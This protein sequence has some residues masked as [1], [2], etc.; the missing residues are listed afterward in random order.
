MTSTT[1]APSIGYDAWRNMGAIEP[2]SPEHYRILDFI[3]HINWGA[4]IEKCY[5]LSGGEPCTISDKYTL[6]RSNFVRQIKFRNGKRWVVRLRLP[7]P[8]VGNED[9]N[10]IACFESLNYLRK[11]TNIP[12]PETYYCDASLNNLLQDLNF[13]KELAMIQV[14]LATKKFDRIG[15]PR[16]A[17]DGKSFEISASSSGL[18][19]GSDID[20]YKYITGEIIQDAARRTQA[21]SQDTT[22]L[23]PA[24]FNTLIARWSNHL[25][26]FGMTITSLGAHNVLVNERFEVQALIDP[27][28]L[29]AA[30][31]EIQAQLPYSMGLQM[32]PPSYIA[33]S[34]MDKLR[35][36]NIMERVKEY[37][38]L[39]KDADR[40]IYGGNLR[41]ADDVPLYRANLG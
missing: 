12:V 22:V 19:F 30:P 11:E 41:A 10:V 9:G 28:G 5:N 21:S 15:R 23:L 31:I 16:P 14:T 8:C 39:L 29:I 18:T 17:A 13:R 34:P 26:P 40:L 36:N 6:G 32:E 38:S 2:Y 37:R 4:V 33:L 27:E 25:G 1:E 35:I 20:Y 3:Q 24:L 7:V